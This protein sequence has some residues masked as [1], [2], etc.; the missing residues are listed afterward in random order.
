MED[1]LPSR[2]RGVVTVASLNVH[3]GVDSHGRPF[4]V[5][6]AVTGLGA[7]VIA[8][9]ET[10][11]KSAEPDPVAVAALAI[12]ARLFRVWLHTDVS[13]SRLGVPAGDDI[14]STGIA[15]LCTL[16]VASH[17]IIDL[18]RMH[19]DL[20]SR[21]A[22]ILTVKVPGSGTV[23]RLAGT[24]LTH[25]FISPVQLGRLVWHLSRSRLPAVIAGDLNMPRQIARFAPGYTPAPRGPTFPAESPFVQL[26]HI[27]ISSGL[28]QV[29]S[30]VL[31]GVGSDH[32]PVRAR[33]RLRADAAQ[34]A[35]RDTGT[36]AV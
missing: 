15:M 29:E 4:D 23:M 22:L 26:D 34:T 12:G 11:V 17:E 20:A 25:R 27:L 21:R 19:G 31:P 16:P 30:V 7:D 33:V 28:D 13:P 10:W 24:H 8:L 14:G 35:R 3:G 5:A 1:S 18:G 9:Q 36:A 32:L 2:E 6:A